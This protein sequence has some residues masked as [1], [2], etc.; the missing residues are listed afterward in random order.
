MVFVLELLALQTST[1][2]VATVQVKLLVME[3]KTRNKSK[4]H[5]VL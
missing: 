1:E 5:Y 2:T 4:T 3:K